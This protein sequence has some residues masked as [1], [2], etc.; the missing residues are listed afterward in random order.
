MKDEEV[1]PICSC[2][3]LL[4]SAF[5]LAHGAKSGSDPLEDE[6]H[7]WIRAPFIMHDGRDFVL[8]RCC[9]AC[10]PTSAAPAITLLHA[11]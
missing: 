3:C 10:F 7:V 5:I 11:D 1:T 4:P 9:F 6:R 2:F 8:K